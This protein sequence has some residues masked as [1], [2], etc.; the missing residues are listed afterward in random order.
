MTKIVDFAARLEA[1]QEE[2]RLAI[3]LFDRAR[4]RQGIMVKP[5]QAM[6]QIGS[7]NEEIAQTLRFIADHL[8]GKE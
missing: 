3:A 4:Q 7:T 2:E 1:K 6:R 5:I 8:E